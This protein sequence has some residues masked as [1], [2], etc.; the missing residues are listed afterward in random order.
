M[1]VEPR[2]LASSVSVGSLLD[3]ARPAAFQVGIDPC[4]ATGG[5]GKRKGPPSM[6]T[7]RV[8]QNAAK[9]THSGQG[10]G[11][12]AVIVTEFLAR[13]GCR[14]SSPIPPPALAGRMS[15]DR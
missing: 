2:Q 7:L 14:S 5:H 3:A 6:G 15:D 13:P 10:G 1:S 11:K 8:L 12:A 4:A 9:A